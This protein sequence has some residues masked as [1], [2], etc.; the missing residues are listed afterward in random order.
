MNASLPPATASLQ[1]DVISDVV[2]PW[3]YIGKRQLEQAL[4]QWASAHP[5]APA[6]IVNWHP[7][8][9][10]PDLPPEGMLRDHYLRRKFGHADGGKLYANVR[11]AAQQ[12]GLKLNLDAIVRQPSTLRPHTL[13]QQAAEQGIQ[14][15]VAEALFQAY[16]IDGRDLSD[17][18]TLRAIAIEAGLTPDRVDLALND[19]QWHEAIAQA[20]LQARQNGVSGVPFFIFNNRLAV[21]GAA[22]A[23]TLVSAMEQAAGAEQAPR[24]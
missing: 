10:N 1:V 13:L 14:D 11:N 6:P 23:D 12:V 9:L 24:G 16:F 20:D 5:D 22:G 3:C 17:S 19:P 2:C 18:E 7:F 8:Q 21:S 15:T 4:G